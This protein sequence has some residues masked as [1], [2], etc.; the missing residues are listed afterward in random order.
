MVCF[1]SKG[2]VGGCCCGLIVL[3]EKGE[4]SFWEGFVDMGDL[5][6]D[7]MVLEC[8]CEESVVCCRLTIVIVSNQVYLLANNVGIRLCPYR[9]ED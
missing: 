9:F 8:F 7:W 4:W 2:L 6:L 5:R 3:V 1:G